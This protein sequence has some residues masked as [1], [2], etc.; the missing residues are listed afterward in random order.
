METALNIYIPFGSL[1]ILIILSLPIYE[2]KMSF[3]LFVSSL[4]FF[5]H[6]LTVSV[7][8]SFPSSV[9][10]IHKYFILLDAIVKGFVY[11]VSLSD[12]SPLAILIETQ[13]I[14]FLPI[15][16]SFLVSPGFWQ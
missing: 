14:Y 11:L 6:Y 8:R 5:H 15:P 3:H 13:L 16:R 12:R 9:K 2:H 10:F 1:N 7:Y 4:I